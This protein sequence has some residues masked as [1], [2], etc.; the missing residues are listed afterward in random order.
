M[1]RN[2][3]LE[4]IYSKQ[5]KGGYDGGRSSWR[6]CAP[7][8]ETFELKRGFFVFG[9][10]IKSYLFP[11]VLIEYQAI[12]TSNHRTMAPLP[13]EIVLVPSILDTDLY[14]V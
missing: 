4:S 13:D 10:G 5:G 1:T 12:W 3:E 11:T 9:T 8:L 7:T 6:G 2:N 14:K